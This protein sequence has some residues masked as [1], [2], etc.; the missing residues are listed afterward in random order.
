MAHHAPDD[1]EP[2]QLADWLEQFNPDTKFTSATRDRVY[3]AAG[4]TKLVPRSNS[5][6]VGPFTPKDWAAQIRRSTLRRVTEK[7]R[8]V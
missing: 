6:L 2:Y 1:L 7:L 4:H 3:A 8:G 5:W